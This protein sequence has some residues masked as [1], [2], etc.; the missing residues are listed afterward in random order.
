MFTNVII[1][2]KIVVNIVFKEILPYCWYRLIITLTVDSLIWNWINNF[3]MNLFFI[4]N[5]MNIKQKYSKSVFYSILIFFPVKEEMFVR[6][7]NGECFC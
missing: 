6:S 1:G 2:T 7:I 4:E 5:W 3:N